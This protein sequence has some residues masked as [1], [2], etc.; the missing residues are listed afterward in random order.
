MDL[1]DLLKTQSSEIL[2]NA[3]Q[4]LNCAYLKSY[5]K[6]SQSENRARLL[7]LLTLTQQCVSERNLLPM[8]EYSSQIARERFNAGFGLHEVHTA[9]NVLEVEIWNRVTKNIAPENLGKA[10]GLVSTV[11]GAGKEELALTYVSLASKSK[12]PTLN[13]TELFGRN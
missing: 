4:S 10:L 5:S 13:L 12:T 6:S 7:N 9:F 11:L 3:H 1:V 2:E 8:K